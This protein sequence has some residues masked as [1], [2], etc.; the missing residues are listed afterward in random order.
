ME[1][2]QDFGAW[3]WARHHN[4]LSWYV[5]PLFLI[6]F[7]YFA[8]RRSLT[9]IAVTLVALAT[10][11]FWFPAPVTPD[12]RSAAFLEAERQYLLGPWNM[13]K[14]AFAALIPAFFIAV[15]IAFWRRSIWIGLAL[16]NAAS[17]IKV[18]WSLHYGGESGWTV[19]PPA[20]I[21]LIT[22]NATTIWAFRRHKIKYSP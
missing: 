16:I 13:A 10:S 8:W 3:A 22:I 14:I 21:G 7:S 17:L 9:G 6:L 12:P 2:L 18:G 1:F 19:V 11:M 4:P 20:L 15:A 5:R